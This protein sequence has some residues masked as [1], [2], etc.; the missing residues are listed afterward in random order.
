MEPT[1][2]FIALILLGAAALIVIVVKVF[3]PLA[4]SLLNTTI[5]GN[6]RTPEEIANIGASFAHWRLTKFE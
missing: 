1:P 6:E 5:D 3:Q 4:E 2:F